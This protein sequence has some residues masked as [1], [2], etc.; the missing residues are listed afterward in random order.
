MTEAEA[1]RAQAPQPLPP[2]GLNIPEFAETRLDNGLAIVIVEDRGL[3]LVSFRLAFRAGHASDPGE[4]PG[5][6]DMMTGLLNEGTESRTS[7]QIAEEVEKLG[8]TLSAGANSD[9][10]TV[11]ASSLSAYSDQILELMADVALHPSFPENEIELTREN[12]KQMLIQQ[13]AQPSFLASERVASVIFGWHPYAIVSPTPASLD[14]M[15]RD[16]F[17]DFHR[18]MLVPDRAVMIATHRASP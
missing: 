7:L 9:Y 5:L 3:P 2:R 4:L 18:S 12:A 15:T 8:A 6:T 13:R 16:T 11:A 1:F 17:L 14:A 10:T